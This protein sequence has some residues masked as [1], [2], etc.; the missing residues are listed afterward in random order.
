MSRRGWIFFAALC[1]IWGLP[2]LMIR[3]A[4][5]EVDPATLVFLRTLPAAMLIIPWAAA[6]GKITP[7]RGAMGWVALYTVVEFGV[8]WFLMSSAEQHLTSS[9]TA[10]L[11]ASVPIL[12]A[13][14]YRFTHVHEP[15]GPR[16]S[17]GLVM[18][19]LGVAA[20]VGLSA[21]GS[22]WLGIAEMAVVVVGY[23]L[24]P[25]IIATKLAHL[26]G[27]GVIGVSISLVALAYLPF[28]VTHLP[29]QLSV[30]SV[31]AIATLAVVC[32]AAGFLIFF[33]LIVE[34]GPARTTVVTYVNPAVAVLLGVS[35][36][37]ESLTKG[38]LIGFPMIIAGS[39]LATGPSA[40]RGAETPGSIDHG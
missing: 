13:V 40:E 15:F 34:V 26:P 38:M 39:I 36:L 1:V 33:A 3:I 19:A 28:G 6:T 8:P 30:S 14:L 9:M 27:S 25:L 29:S 37:G 35:F 32:T 23:A 7:L 31:A 12:A 5:R 21:S 4:V 10:L 17:A 18:G 20:L 16:R 22:S 2:Y 24:G 11:V